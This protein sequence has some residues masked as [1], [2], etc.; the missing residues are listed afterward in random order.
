MKIFALYSDVVLT[1][2]PEW[3]DGFR[4]QFN[5]AWDLHITLK[6]PCFIQDKDIDQ[7]KSVV[8][9]FFST[10][11]V[12][13]HELNLVFKRVVIKNEE[14]GA[15]IMFMAEPNEVLADLQRKL[16]ESLR[17]YSDYVE[18]ESQS[19]ERNFQPHITIAQH[20]SVQ[21]LNEAEKV[22]NSGEIGEALINGVTL[23]I[24][25]ELTVDES[26]R[27]TNKTVYKL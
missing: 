20:L 16:C 21:Q 1:K 27:P 6:Q 23:S 3:L 18:S 2:Q 11:S 25:K 26:R 17:Q 4:K 22:L 9:K 10:F 15:I 7:L 24:V 5:E 19:Y 14:D 13:K 8:S 12:S